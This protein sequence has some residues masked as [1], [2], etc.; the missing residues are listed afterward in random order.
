MAAF[1]HDGCSMSHEGR[2][3][4]LEDLPK[5]RGQPDMAQHA[6]AAGQTL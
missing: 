6:L 2:P 5:R 1:L 4:G 3:T